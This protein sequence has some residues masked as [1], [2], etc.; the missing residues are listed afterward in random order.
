M[1]LAFWL[2]MNEAEGYDDV[3]DTRRAKINAIGKKLRRKGYAGKIVPREVFAQ[4]LYKHH[5]NMIT[6]DE[7]IYIEDEFL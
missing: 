2:Y 4:L 5:L 7:K 3:V 6:E 1:E